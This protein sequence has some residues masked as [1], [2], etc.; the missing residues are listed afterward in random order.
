MIPLYQRDIRRYASITQ[1]LEFSHAVILAA[2]VYLK[3]LT[4]SEMHNLFIQQT[5]GTYESASRLSRSSPPLAKRPNP[6][7]THYHH[8]IDYRVT[9]MAACLGENEPVPVRCD[10]IVPSVVQERDD[11]GDYRC[12]SRRAPMLIQ[13]LYTHAIIV[14][15]DAE[16]TGTQWLEYMHRTTTTVHWRA[17]KRQLCQRR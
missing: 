4:A 3:H 14:M 16:L 9:L 5:L 13:P 7:Q 15:Q 6:R 8:A 12:S 2:F 10:S 11:C 17:R 1:Y